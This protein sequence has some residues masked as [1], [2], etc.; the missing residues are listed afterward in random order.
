M[1]SLKMLRSFKIFNI[2]IFD[3][4]G[5]FMVTYVFHI[6]MEFKHPLWMSMVCSILL[7]VIVH[8]VTDTPTMLN[9]YLGLS[10]KP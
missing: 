9:Y 5:T 8:M 3:L 7:G 1:L 6:F 10:N 2:A 4:L